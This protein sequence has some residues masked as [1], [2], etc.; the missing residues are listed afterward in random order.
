VLQSIRRKFQPV[1]RERRE[2]MDNDG[3]AKAEM[4]VCPN[5]HTPHVLTRKEDNSW[6][7]FCG[8]ETTS[9]ETIR[10]NG[11]YTAEQEPAPTGS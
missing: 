7:L 9:V 8:C 4:N 6:G 5:C 11:E 1:T 2:G 10:H 3:E